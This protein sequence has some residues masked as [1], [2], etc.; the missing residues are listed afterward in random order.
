M[1][2][3]LSKFGGL[4]CSPDMELPCFPY[5]IWISLV[6]PFP[7]FETSFKNSV[8]VE[9]FQP[10]CSKCIRWRLGSCVFLSPALCPRKT[11]T[12]FYGRYLFDEMQIEHQS[13]YYLSDE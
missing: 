8:I 3:F 4:S 1:S 6:L 7:Y 11:D 12:G 13:V 5:N 10:T 2:Y 9:K